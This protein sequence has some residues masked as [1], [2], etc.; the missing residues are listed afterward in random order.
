MIT[1][2]F[3]SYSLVNGGDLGNRVG[4]VEPRIVRPFGDKVLKVNGS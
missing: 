4:A 3:L 1:K 2:N